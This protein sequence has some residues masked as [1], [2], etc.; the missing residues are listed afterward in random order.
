MSI[1]R[2][3]SQ[4]RKTSK[5]QEVPTAASQQLIDRKQRIHERE[6]D[7]DRRA[8]VVDA[9][10]KESSLLEMLRGKAGDVAKAFILIN[11]LFVAFPKFAE[12]ASSHERSPSVALEAAAE[13][14]QAISI[15]SEGREQT[16][17][18]ARAIN[19]I[20]VTAISNGEQV[21]TVIAPEELGASS[22]IE[23][24][25]YVARVMVS[26]KMRDAE[27]MM[28]G[29]KGKVI[30]NDQGH[31]KAGNNLF[32]PRDIK[33]FDASKIQSTS[34]FF[35]GNN[36]NTLFGSAPEDSRYFGEAVS[37]DSV[38][39]LSIR[40]AR[41]TYDI[42]I[43][44]RPTERL[45]EH[46]SPSSLV[47]YQG[48]R[49]QDLR[50]YA[51]HISALRKGVED[52]EKLYGSD[53]LNTISIIDLNK[54][55]AGVPLAHEKR[56]LI[57]LTGLFDE[58]L[59]EHTE[60]VGE[61]E[62]LHKVVS[63]RGYADDLVLKEIFADIHGAK[64]TKRDVILKYGSLPSLA[65]LENNDRPFF[66]FINESDYHDTPNAGHAEENMDE[67]MASFLHT[68]MDFDRF[69]GRLE[70]SIYSTTNRIDEKPGTQELPIL[71][72][73]DKILTRLSDIAKDKTEK[74]AYM[75]NLE[76]IR[77]LIDQYKK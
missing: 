72:T 51:E 20:I 48:N 42:Q 1:E 62:A 7:M 9:L 29:K 11:S 13:K 43:R 2:R 59:P 3:Y 64:G 30:Q 17:E 40:T 68:Q 23:V 58:R 38:N 69:S 61:H 25:G 35:S 41:G 46:T 21:S 28:N 39:K 10:K 57:I 45:H 60:I 71:E 22:S 56:S 52:V 73:Y 54:N 12:G 27:I 19:S 24:D 65:F 74:Q 44:Q 50:R 63:E 32:S 53:V 67:F 76:T 36:N 16:P 33:M 4:D 77:S 37:A 31:L 26:H 18:E 70:R 66:N 55:N 5:R 34:E 75:K 49:K 6:A 47:E 8:Q 14:R 15:R